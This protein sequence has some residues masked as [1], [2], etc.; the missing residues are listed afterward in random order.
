MFEKVKKKHVICI[1]CVLLTDFPE[2]SVVSAPMF[3]HFEP[4]NDFAIRCIEHNIEGRIVN[5]HCLIDNTYVP[6]KIHTRYCTSLVCFI[7]QSISGLCHA[8]ASYTI[9][10]K[11]PTQ[12]SPR[13]LISCSLFKMSATTAINRS[14]LN[15][16]THYLN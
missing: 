8:A 3:F 15:I 11:S 4:D 16:K 12:A 13:I 14:K 10:L 7:S 5:K 9:S 1:I 2:R 6:T